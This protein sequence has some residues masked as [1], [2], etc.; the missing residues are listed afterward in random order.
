[1]YSNE[2]PAIHEEPQ[3]G[4]CYCHLSMHSEAHSA[5]PCHHCE[6]QV[7]REWPEMFEPDPPPP[8]L[9]MHFEIGPLEIVELER[10]TAA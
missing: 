6:E 5:R 7:R 1:M 2:P 8:P 3:A 10:K 9:P 4:Q